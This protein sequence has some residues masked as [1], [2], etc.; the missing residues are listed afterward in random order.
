MKKDYIVK[1]EKDEWG[2]ILTHVYEHKKNEVK[3]DGFRKGQVPYDI[4]VKNFGLE[5]LYM[6]AV[7]HALP[8]LYDKM[9]E[10]NTDLTFNMACR[11]EVDVK[12]ISNCLLY[13]SPSPRDS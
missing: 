7:D 8:E 11:P 2:K 13:T 9:L 1:M 12:S 6:D 10:E 3:V 4:Y 5:S